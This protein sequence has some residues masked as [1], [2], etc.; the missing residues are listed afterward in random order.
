MAFLRLYVF[1]HHI[2]LRYIQPDR[3]VV[4]RRGVRRAPGTWSS[5]PG[6]ALRTALR[7]YDEKSRVTAPRVRGS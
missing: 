2:L 3:G 1:S 6:T 4:R 7:L 5:A